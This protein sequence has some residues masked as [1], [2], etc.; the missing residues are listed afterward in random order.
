MLQNL[1]S[2]TISTL[3]AKLFAGVKFSN[4]QS[5]KLPCTSA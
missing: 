1:F 4:D 2:T 3:H 5:A